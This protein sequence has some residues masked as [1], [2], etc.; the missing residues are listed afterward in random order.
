MGYLLWTAAGL[1]VVAG[2]VVGVAGLG[3]G[4][5][6]QEGGEQDR[7]ASPRLGLGPALPFG[8]F[9]LTY[10]GFLVAIVPFTIPF[11]F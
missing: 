9:A 3:V 2:A 11:L 8:V 4:L 1:M 5:G 6:G 10:L 7:T